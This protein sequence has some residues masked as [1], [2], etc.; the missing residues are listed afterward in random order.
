MNGPM[1]VGLAVLVLGTLF[2]LSRGGG[3]RADPA[4]V[5]ALV[6]KGARLVDVRSSGEFSGGHLPG[7]KNIPLDAISRRLTELGPKD[8]PVVVYC[9]S[10][11]RS[12][13]AAATLRAAGFT[14][15][16]DL[17]AMGNW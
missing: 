6:A 14:A 16:H 7:A 3:V 1:W 2:L 11:A 17:G 13:Q 10:G 5:K 9:R 8:G 15:V 12:A 4:T